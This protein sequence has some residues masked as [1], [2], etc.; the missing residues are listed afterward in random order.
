MR[1]KNAKATRRGWHERRFEPRATAV[2][3]SCD[4]CGRAMWLP[5]SK[6]SM[7]RTCGGECAEAR[8]RAA[9]EAR[10]RP[11]ETCGERFTPRA[12]QVRLGQGKYCSQKCNPSGQEVLARPGIRERMTATRSANVSKWAWKCMGK[13]SPRWKGG[14][15]ATY[16]R[17]K[18]LGYIRDQNNKRRDYRRRSLPKGFIPLLEKRQRMRCAT[19]R[20]SLASGY[21]LDHIVPISK[22]GGHEPGNVQLLCPPC[23]MRKSDRMPHEWARMNGRLL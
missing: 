11:C 17:R 5:R 8:K 15:Q 3:T 2:E 6:V 10:T 23:N 21:H 19:C 20:S 18:A 14:R 7:Y 22:G 1:T 12:R 16:E 4:Q 9:V 13:N